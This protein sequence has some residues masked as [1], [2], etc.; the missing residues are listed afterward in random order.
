MDVK[1]AE[2]GDSGRQP[3]RTC[4]TYL[5]QIR[6]RLNLRSYWFKLKKKTLKAQDLQKYLRPQSPRTC[7]IIKLLFPFDL[8]VS[9]I[10][11]YSLYL[12]RCFKYKYKYKKNKNVSIPSGKKIETTAELSLYLH[13][14]FKPF[15]VYFNLCRFIRRYILAVCGRSKYVI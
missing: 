10:F 1:E 9:K 5:Y 2:A 14:Y 6:V 7:K 11:F 12:S 3:C 4:K 13:T 8:K 15:L